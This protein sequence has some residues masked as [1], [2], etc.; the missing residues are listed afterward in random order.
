M[1]NAE[2]NEHGGARLNLLLPDISE[3]PKSGYGKKC[4]PDANL[5][6][7]AIFTDQSH[8]TKVSEIK[9]SKLFQEK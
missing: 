8:I 2:G 6:I 7:A 1:N 4:E 5:E 3:E 9:I